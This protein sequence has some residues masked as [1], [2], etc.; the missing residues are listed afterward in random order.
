MVVSSGTFFALLPV[1]FI[2]LGVRG[3]GGIGSAFPMASLALAGVF[4][5]FAVICNAAVAYWVEPAEVR[6][7]YT[8]AR[9]KYKY[10]AQV[11]PRTNR[12][13]RMPGEEFLDADE[14]RRRVATVR[15]LGK[16]GQHLADGE[17][18]HG[19]L[20]GSDKATPVVPVI[21]DK[22]GNV[23]A[24]GDSVVLLKDPKAKSSS[25]V[26]KAGTEVKRIRL[27]FERDDEKVVS[28]DLPGKAR[29]VLESK[30]VKKI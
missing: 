22:A 16:R 2:T 5:V 1:F 26:V 15:E 23:L 24:D 11:D 4:A 17:D 6:A 12:I 14:F 25:L 19:G 18:A 29:F 13:I 9:S 3:A 21:V 27:V 28:V 20:A 8:T 30:F 7:G 10:I